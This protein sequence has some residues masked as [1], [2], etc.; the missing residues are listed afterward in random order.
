M[1][2]TINNTTTTSQT[3]D[4]IEPEMIKEEVE[5]V[6]RKAHK[7]QKSQGFGIDNMLAELLTGNAWIIRI[8]NA[9]LNSKQN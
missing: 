8:F 2:P 1:P 3:M 7:K 5:N 9:A 4:E 6:L